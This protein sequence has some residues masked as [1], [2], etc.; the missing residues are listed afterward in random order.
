MQADDACYETGI[1]WCWF[2]VRCGATVAV[3]RA[4]MG[5]AFCWNLLEALDAPT[6]HPS[7][8]SGLV[9]RHGSRE[10]RA[11][12]AYEGPSNSEV[13]AGFAWLEALLAKESAFLA[14]EGGPAQLRSTWSA[15]HGVGYYRAAV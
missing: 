7:A 1:N 14:G 8:K 2:W 12:P 9:F 4:H 15:F 11:A 5:E 13:P 10:R 6:L 3:F